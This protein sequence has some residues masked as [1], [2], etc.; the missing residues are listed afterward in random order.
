M[1]PFNSFSS[2]DGGYNKYSNAKEWSVTVAKATTDVTF[3]TVGFKAHIKSNGTDYYAYIKRMNNP[4]KK[5]DDDGTNVTTHYMSYIS[6]VGIEDKHYTNF[7][8]SFINQAG[9]TE[10]AKKDIREYFA[11]PE[12]VILLDSVVVI[13]YNK[14]P[15][16]FVDDQ[17]I[18]KR[19][20]DKVKVYDTKAGFLSAEDWGDKTKKTVHS[21]YDIKVP[22]AIQPVELPPTAVITKGTSETPTSYE[23]Y[24]KGDVIDLV[25]RKSWF[26]DNVSKEYQWYY[27][28]QDSDTWI[29]GGKNVALKTSKLNIGKYNVK[30]HTRYRQVCA[31]LPNAVVKDCIKDAEAVINIK[32]NI[33]IIPNLKV[34]SPEDIELGETETVAKIPV[35]IQSTLS[36]VTSVK[37]VKKVEY[38]LTTAEGTPVF[39]ETLAPTLS[40]NKTNVFNIPYNGKPFTQAFKGKVIYTLTDGELRGNYD[41]AFSYTYIHKKEDPIDPSDPPASQNEPPVPILSA[42]PD[43]VV[44][45]DFRLDGSKSFDSDGEVVSWDF[46]IPQWGY[47]YNED[48]KESTWKTAQSPG[49][50]IQA[51]LSVTDDKGA[52]SETEQFFNVTP[53]KP[54]L[55]IDVE[56]WLKENRKV[57]F[58]SNVYN[59]AGYTTTD[60]QVTWEIRPFDGQAA[61]GIKARSLTGKKIE[62]LF[63]EKGSYS[64][65]CTAL[66]NA[67]MSSTQSM[68]VKIT[69]DLK[70]EVVVTAFDTFYRDSEKN[71]EMEFY[72]NSGSID[73]DYI[74]ERSWY[75][76]FDSNNNGSF[77][78]E[79]LKYLKSATLPEDNALKISTNH[80]GKYRI[81]LSVKEG[82][83][84][85]TLP[86]FIT[87]SDY[88]RNSGYK[89]SEVDNHAPV[90]SFIPTT[91]KKIDVVVVTDYTGEKLTQLGTRLNNYVG[92][93]LDNYLNVKLQ[94]A[95]DSKYLGRYVPEDAMGWSTVPDATTGKYEVA[96]WKIYSGD[97]IEYSDNTY[98]VTATTINIYQGDTAKTTNGTFPAR[99]KQVQT[100]KYMTLILLENGE[101][102]VLGT[103]SLCTRPYGNTNR[104]ALEPIKVL[105]NVKTMVS[106]NKIDNPMLTYV[107]TNSGEVYAS[108]ELP[109]FYK[110]SGTYYITTDPETHLNL[111]NL[112]STVTVDNFGYAR[113]EN[114][115]SNKIV[116]TEIGLSKVNGLANIT[117]GKA[118]AGGFVARD[119]G[120]NWWGFGTSLNGLGHNTG[121][122][123]TK[124]NAYGSEAASISR[125][126]YHFDEF[127]NVVKLDNLSNLDKLIGGI[128]EVDF[129]TAYARNGDIY[130]IKQNPNKF[131]GEVQL[132]KPDGAAE[133]QG[134][135]AGLTYE[136]ISQ[137]DTLYNIYYPFQLKGA[138][139]FTYNKTGSGYKP[140][141]T[142]V[143]RNTT[144]SQSASDYSASPY[145][146]SLLQ[147]YGIPFS[148]TTQ[149]VENSGTPYSTPPTSSITQY[150]EA[151][152][153]VAS[154]VIN[155]FEQFAY[156]L[157]YT[158]V[159]WTTGS[160]FYYTDAERPK[161]IT[162]YTRTGDYTYKITG[163]KTEPASTDVVGWKFYGVDM[164]KLPSTAFR[165]NSEKYI[166]YL[167]DKD[168]FQKIDPS[169]LAYIKANNIKVKVATDYKYVDRSTNKAIEINLRDMINATP[170][171]KLYDSNGLETMLSDITAENKVFI[172]GQEGLYLVKGEDTAT[173]STYYNDLENDPKYSQVFNHLQDANY[174]E[175]SE[176]Q[177]AYHNIQR[178]EPV[179]V[180]DK[181]GKYRVFHK[182]TDQPTPEVAFQSYNRTSDATEM[183]VFVHRRPIADF[184]MK[185]VYN[186]TNINFSVSSTSYD[187]D[188]LSYADKGIKF[189]EWKWKK[190]NSTA[191]VDGMP[192]LIL[193]YGEQ[194][195]VYLKV[196][197]YEG[198]TSSTQKT[199]TMPNEAPFDFGATLTA[200]K[201]EHSLLAFPRG[202]NVV[203]INTWS[204]YPYNHHLETALYDG[205]TRVGPIKTINMILGATATAVDNHGFN[206]TNIIYNIPGTL[207]GKTYTMKITAISD[208]DPSKTKTVSQNVTVTANLAPTISFKTTT[209]SDP[210]E[211]DQITSTV[212][213][214]DPDGDLL[215]LDYYLWKEGETPKLIQTFNNQVQGVIKTLPPFTADSYGVYYQKVVVTDPSGASATANKTI[216]VN[217]IAVSGVVTPLDP[218]AGD[219]L[220]FKITTTG[221]VDKVEIIPDQSWIVNDKRVSMGYAAASYEPGLKSGT[222]KALRLEMD[223]NNLVDTK[224][225]KYIV[226]VSTPQTLTLK[227]QRLRAPYEITLRAWK[228]SVYRDT[229]ITIELEGSVIQTFKI[230][231]PNK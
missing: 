57:I 206:W 115:E 20:G 207:P 226:W 94:V 91:E 22:F 17:G 132:V 131:H 96:R 102:Y 186:Q 168:S 1:L 224:T 126:N 58:N 230:G 122:V 231:A 214:I 198:A 16:G 30:L 13:N 121:F 173:Y 127:N 31:W 73:G 98:N 182:G 225:L 216:V 187:L 92:E 95:T 136:I 29:D 36:G 49:N 27:K 195:D 170:N 104:F 89:I 211:G 109:K 77:E 177:S 4:E 221:K 130:S 2:N 15:Q 185:N 124:F 56:G 3:T 128:A 60:S 79:T 174:F 138:G 140:P 201:P 199:F 229:T 164:S 34:T 42:I 107:I 191:W 80:V 189:A 85:E 111:T 145:Y 51:I 205:A 62:T 100:R 39:S 45:S 220:T 101:L 167:G 203:W 28:S 139:T 153:R 59:V 172:E 86:E 5:E 160:Y 52:Y 117:Y 143:K 97:L 26:P 37:N 213:P 70:P 69:E 163:Y 119:S 116:G 217:K 158:L 90:V 44:G 181:V 82:F 159:N 65:E 105:S 141:Q 142:L 19:D 55:N 24:F 202:N 146:N 192:N 150:F 78:D 67:G 137:F 48:G 54:M 208:V 178:T 63:K 129:N 10:K 166:L 171:G 212:M 50:Q 106:N 161:K 103:N 53:P 38:I 147:D 112:F 156:K 222:Y 180:F 169:I 179:T 209:P 87:D 9:T 6:N 25:G 152:L 190:A 184:E 218:M 120:G 227:K 41:W 125:N 88:K 223:E 197:D 110:N 196:T 12:R 46:Y 18:P 165:P 162:T 71:T 194:V 215:K 7:Y 123:D 40:V 43:V 35:N 66:N 32:P 228:G 118:L 134:L 81:Y 83:G 68:I 8:S 135:E 75:Y 113:F 21:M 210:Y 154:G 151:P 23:E 133:I 14:V 93:S 74:A 76:A 148:G 183:D 155:T 64:V 114:P 33:N 144:P 84:Q 149:V 219:R 204:R 200:E 193:N 188:H 175:N 108:G 61:T 47:S 72:D 176:G 157:E 99:I 11:G